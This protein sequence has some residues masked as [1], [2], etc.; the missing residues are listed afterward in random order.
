MAETVIER[1]GRT[2]VIQDELPPEANAMAM[3]LYSR[4][5]RSILVHLVEVAKRGWQKFMAI[6]Y[7]GYGHK[8]IGDC[9]TTNIHA[10][11]VSMLC[12]KAIQHNRLYNGQEASTRYLDMTT[13]PVLNPLETPE[14]KAIQDQWMGCYSDVL[15]TLTPHLTE[16]Y[17]R[18]E[19]DDPKQ[20]EK[21]IK[22]KAF[23]IA[24][25]FLPAGCT[26]Y[27][28]WHSTLRQAADHLKELSFH[29][30]EEVKEVT[31][32]ILEGLRERY[33]SSF[34][35]KSYESQDQYLA[36]CGEQYYFRNIVPDFWWSQRFDWRRLLQ[37]ETHVE[38]LRSRP[39]KTELPDFFDKYGQIT[40]QFRL[41]FG[42]FRDLQRHR[43]CMQAMPLLTTHVGFNEWY[44]AQLP[45]E[46]R[47]YVISVLAVQESA[48]ARLE[49]DGPQQQYYVAMGYNVN[50]ELVAGLPSAIYIAEL[51]S[52]QAVHPTLRIIAQK[53]GGMLRDLCPEAALYVDYSPDEWTTIRGKHDIV[54]KEG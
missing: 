40:F 30:L 39:V 33:P 47:R 34:N 27:V 12:A 8:S 31:A 50:C 5:P 52:T 35:G 17:P 41:D 51:R 15:A 25:G 38:L 36:K 29:P 7:V 1:G 24:R 46:L 22:A 54:K 14:G 43:S 13:M 37:N 19:N 2:V 48:I 26:T 49:C 10:E 11:Q 21:A 32:Q 20:Y 45:T 53:M 44:L 9:G 16:K 18:L 42:S 6:F 4:D 3:A 23:D 28:G